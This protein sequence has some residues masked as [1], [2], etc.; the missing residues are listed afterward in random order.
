MPLKPADLFQTIKA[1]DLEHLKTLPKDQL[2]GVD[3]EENTALYYAIES[4]DLAMVRYLYQ[5]G[6]ITI[7]SEKIRIKAITLI[8]DALR[9]DERVINAHPAIRD[10]KPDQHIHWGDCPL[11]YAASLG[12]IAIF[13][14]LHTVGGLSVYAPMNLGSLLETPLSVAIKANQ[15]HM[16]K[17][18]LKNFPALLQQLPVLHFISK[19]HYY[20]STAIENGD[21]IIFSYL[22]AWDNRSWPT[23]NEHKSPLAKAVD[24]QRKDIAEAMLADGRLSLD[25]KTTALSKLICLSTFQANDTFSKN[26]TRLQWLIENNLISIHF[27][28]QQQH[29]ADNISLLQMAIKQTTENQLPE[30]RVLAREFCIYLL[31]KGAGIGYQ[32]LKQALQDLSATDSE[33]ED[34]VAIG[35]DINAHDPRFAKMI[36]STID[37]QKALRRENTIDRPAIKKA[38]AYLLQLPLPQ[39]ADSPYQLTP[40]AR[41]ELA[42]IQSRNYLDFLYPNVSL[43]NICYNFLNYHPQ[44]RPLIQK[45]A[46]ALWNNLPPDF[47]EKIRPPTPL[48]DTSPRFKKPIPLQSPAEPCKPPTL[49]IDPASRF[50]SQPRELPLPAPHIAPTHMADPIAARFKKPAPLPNPLAGLKQLWQFNNLP[51]YVATAALGVLGV[52]LLGLCTFGLVVSIVS[53]LPLLIS[54]LAAVG[55]TIGAWSVVS[56]IALSISTHKQSGTVKPT[57]MQAEPLP[58]AT[59]LANVRKIIGP[60]SKP[61]FALTINK[62]PHTQEALMTNKTASI[63]PQITN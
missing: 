28:V 50:K 52:G 36:H 56:S 2:S 17:Y 61:I 30:N 10:S 46:T 40:A 7:V 1:G 19:K 12:Q 21:L 53:Q 6:I 29:G 8:R 55:A 3:E 11:L 43:S 16:V 62:T 49:F 22:Y 48:V 39:P 42:L 32:G 24:L 27:N 63:S 9:S 33:L 18:L 5:Q 38:I 23:A 44:G 54:I 37:L 45:D 15:R 58:P 41:K 20:L 34:I 4:R 57:I 13:E 14:W 47:K 31:Q 25:T 26:I 60:V 59:Q 35:S 51:L